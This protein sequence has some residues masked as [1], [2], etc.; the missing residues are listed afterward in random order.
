[1]SSS[2]SPTEAYP[3]VQAIKPLVIADDLTLQQVAFAMSYMV[4]YNA[5]RAAK[6][7]GVTPDTGRNW[8]RR[9][10]VRNYIITSLGQKATANLITESYIEQHYVRLM[11]MLMG[12]EK[13]PMVV[14]GMELEAKEFNAAS[15]LSALRDMA[16]S[17]G[18]Q[19]TIDDSKN[20]TVTVNVAN[21]LGGGNGA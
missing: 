6:E 19:K 17:T 21:L 7:V 18:F 4:D 8:A 16:K 12:D 14:N 20:V 3:A 11:P 15:A 1:M 5:S 2:T 13:V 10:S 9:E